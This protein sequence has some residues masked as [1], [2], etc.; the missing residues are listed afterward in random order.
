MAEQVPLWWQIPQLRAAEEDRRASWLELFI[1]L[2][3]VAIISALAR[4]LAV[5]ITWLGVAAF[6]LVF[7][8]AWWIWTGL[9]IYNDRFETDDVSHRLAFFAVLIALGGMAVSAKHFFTDGFWLYALS[10]VLARVVIIVLWVRAG[11]HN[12]TARPLTTRYAVGFGIAAAMWLVALAVPWPVRLDVI[13]LAILIDFAT[14]LA[15]LRAQEDLPRLSATHLP[16]RFGLFII[17]VLGEA[18]IGVEA[19]AALDFSRGHLAQA[20]I[21]PAMLAVAFV[22]W[23]LYFDHVAENPPPA[24]PLLSMAWAYPHLLLALVLGTFGAAAQALVGA[25]RSHE[26]PAL[27]LACTSVGLAFATIA[28]LEFVTEPG[29]E[30][31]HPARSLGVHLGAAALAIALSLIAPRLGALYVM[32]LLTALGVGQIVY[33]YA[34]RSHHFEWDAED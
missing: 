17:I 3:F 20:A 9:T 4:Q 27:A 2:M 18:V 14:P 23:W 15:T 12:P 21:G 29:A 7:L 28:L 33:G 11:Y 34:T 24:S 13:V 6:T 32:L 25:G 22:L 31:H 19:A 26:P 30:R 5:D 8:P 16:E 1:D 10:Y